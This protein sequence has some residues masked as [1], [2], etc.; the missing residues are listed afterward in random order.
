MKVENHGATEAYF[1]NYHT[2]F[3]GVRN[4]FLQVIGPKG[5]EIDYRGMMA[6]R[7]APGPEHYIR[8]EPGTSTEVEFDPSEAYSFAQSGLYR[9]K[10][11]GNESIN[12]L[13]DSEE[14][15]INIP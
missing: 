5:K 6:K 3:E 13:P 2:P 11:I 8:L 9:L 7:L 10:F 15:R 4:I 1:C 12:G 14:I